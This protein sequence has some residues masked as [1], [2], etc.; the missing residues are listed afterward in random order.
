MALTQISTQGIK[1]GTITGTDLATN[2]DL[3]D[4][5]KLRLGTGADLQIYH[6]GTVNRFISSGSGAIS[7]QSGGGNF[8]FRKGTSEALLKLIPDGAVELYHNNSKRL[9]TTSQ[10]VDLGFVDGNIRFMAA[11]GSANI[12]INTDDS[13]IKMWDNSKIV[14]GASSDLQIFH[15]SS[16]GNSHINESGSG[17]LVIKATNTYINNSSDEQMIAAIAD[18]AVELYHDNSKKLQTESWGVDI[19]GTLRADTL[20]LSD[21]HKL[22]FGIG[23]DLEIYHDGSDSYIKDAGT[24]QLLIFT[25][26]FRLQNAAGN[27]QQIAA[28]EDGA[29]DLF[30]DGSKK[31]ETTSIGVKVSANSSVDGLLVTAPLEG[32]VTVADERGASF[33]AS[34]FMAG[35]APAIRNQN[36]STSDSTLVIQKGVSTVA[37]WDGNGHYLPGA[38]NTYDIGSTSLRWRNIYTNDLNLSNEGSAN[39]VDGTWG[40]YTIQEG[41]EDLFLINKRNGKKYKFNLTEVS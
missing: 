15:D 12:Y 33:K 20:K 28:N 39:D 31:F 16:N 32:T 36:T 11:N 3:V 41:A 34:F 23:N 24:G 29:V 18:G 9:E 22:Q 21:D 26:Q 30:Y 40:S 17:S 13:E 5:Q 1:D 6:D 8:L 38:N 25:N 7:F 4:N 37:Q 10:G 14:M 35:S 2:V 19:T 27:E